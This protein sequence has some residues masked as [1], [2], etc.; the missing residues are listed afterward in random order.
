[1]PKTANVKLNLPQYQKIA[2]F[3]LGV[4]LGII[5]IQFSPLIALGILGV[6]FSIYVINRRPEIALLGIL[7]ATSS[8]VFEEKLPLIS[9]GS[10]SFHLSDIVL[11]GCLGLIAIRRLIVAEFKILHS[12]LDWPLL[13]FCGVTLLST[14]IA[15]S[16]SSVDVVDARRG[17]RVL[18]YYLTFFV[19]TNLVRQLRQLNFLLNGIFLLASVVAV[20]MVAQFLM[21]N[22]IRL[23]SG[24]VEGLET[25]GIQY[26]N[27][28]RIAPPGLSI[29][30]VS[31]VAILCILIIE[32]ARQFR[33]LRNI[34]FALLGMA[35]LITF[36]RSYYAA[37]FI[38]LFLLAYLLKDYDKRRLIRG[39]V[40]GIFSAALIML[41]VLSDPGSRATRLLGASLDRLGTLIWSKT[42]QGQDNSFN[43]RKIEN[44][45]AFSIIPSHPLF[46]LGMGAR[47]RPRD[48]RIDKRRPSVSDY[49]FR[50]HIHNGHLWIIL[51]SGL[52][53]YISLMWL[54]LTFII[55]GLKY[56][57]KIADDRGR[58]VVLGFTLVYLALL[59][60]SWV[61]STFVQW[62]WTPVIGLLMGIN[63]VILRKA[64][65]G[66]RVA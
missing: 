16:H 51:Q 31:F 54:S 29:V 18:A 22:S 15:I 42:Y 56:W 21:G 24:R 49:D 14:F 2:A 62:R 35:L 47:Y 30:L 12:P 34:Q 27:I 17:I 6:G 43:W 1:M 45:Y 38:V 65:L 46:G 10:I 40:V 33:W 28:A 32:K 26:E 3:S 41:V 50:K 52:L 11:L 48:F 25:Q 8:I 36:L 20:A 44:R 13:A 59:A 53:G 55:R 9:V 63:E 7:V 66:S 57:R 64:R 37:L 19:V 60:A 61:N 23:L 5:S 4:V 58:G 39:A